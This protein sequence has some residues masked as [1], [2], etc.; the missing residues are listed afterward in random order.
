MSV[1]LLLRI[2]SVMQLQA[3]GGRMM[4]F[5]SSIIFVVSRV[6]GMTDFIVT[7]NIIFN[8]F[9]IFN[10]FIIWLSLSL[11]ICFCWNYS[12]WLFLILRKFLLE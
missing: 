2:S 11:L 1:Q 10:I 5:D 3:S 9:R 4:S 6:K 12:T 7:I 8:H